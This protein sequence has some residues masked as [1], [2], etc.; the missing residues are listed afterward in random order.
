MV[1]LLVS[2]TTFLLTAALIVV[3]GDSG[4]IGDSSSIGDSGG[5]GDLGNLCDLRIDSFSRVGHGSSA[6]MNVGME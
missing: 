3:V 5:V 1:N 6:M 2:A 4:S